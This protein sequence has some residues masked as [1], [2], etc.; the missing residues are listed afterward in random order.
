MSELALRQRTNQVGLF[1]FLATVAMLF[2]AF[3]AAYVI[4]RSGP[5]WAPIELPPL[6][7]PNTA[8]LLAS[9]VTVEMARKRGR[10]WLA[11]TGVLGIVFA[12]GQI[13]VLLRLAAA[14]V[15]LASSPHA[16]FVYVLAGVHG[17]HLAGGLG[18]IGRTW[19]R[20]HAVPL[21]ATYW[22]FLGAIWLYILLLLHLS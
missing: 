9:S 16:S 14:G 8:L 10:A 17:A 20:P 3:T 7:W 2:T 22:H 11:A 4:R 1:A 18:A 12:L 21:F 19:S 5:D 15:F 13:A 6:V